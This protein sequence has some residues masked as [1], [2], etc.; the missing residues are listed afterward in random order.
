MTDHV[1]GDVPALARDAAGEVRLSAGQ[2]VI[3]A[4][5][6]DASHV[7]DESGELCAEILASGDDPCC[8]LARTI[9]AWA[10]VVSALEAAEAR[11]GL[12]YRLGDTG[13]TMDETARN[14][15]ESIEVI[16]AMHSRDWAAD[17]GD[18]WLWGIVLG[19]TD[20][21]MAEVAERHG[22]SD[23]TVARIRRQ[24]AAWVALRDLV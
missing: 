11:V 20:G 17:P 6:I 7:T 1:D 3:V 19:W 23:Q 13:R 15:L 14:A 12:I 5:H 8:A 4:G 21:A 22:W 18:A 9:L 10:P 16:M 2:A 24:R